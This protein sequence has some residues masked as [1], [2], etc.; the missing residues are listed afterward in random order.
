MV[1]FDLVKLF[2]KLLSTPLLFFGIFNS[3]HH[4]FLMPLAFDKGFSKFGNLSL[5]KFDFLDKYGIVHLPALMI[6]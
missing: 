4:S 2:S 5:K 3:K 1:V 6:T